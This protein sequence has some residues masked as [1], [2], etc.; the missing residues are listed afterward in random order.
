ML[1]RIPSP[2]R[3]ALLTIKT[4]RNVVRQRL[5][6]THIQRLSINMHLPVVTRRF[7]VLGSAFTLAG[8]R[9]TPEVG[10]STPIQQELCSASRA[11]RNRW[12]RMVYTSAVVVVRSSIPYPP[13]MLLDWLSPSMPTEIKAQKT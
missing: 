11:A 8:V 4:V 6:E 10:R 7:R 12:S 1:H 9:Y 5:P 2:S 3:H 13:A